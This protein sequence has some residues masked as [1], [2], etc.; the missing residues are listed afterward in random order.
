VRKGNKPLLDAVNAALAD[1][2]RDGSYAR[3]YAAWFG[4]QPTWLPG[5]ASPSSAP[6]SSSHG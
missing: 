4:K 6:T 1:S 2:V 5:A 3:I